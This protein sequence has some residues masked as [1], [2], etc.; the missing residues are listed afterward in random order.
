MSLQ[1]KNFIR[2]LPEISNRIKMHGF[3][4][5]LIILSPPPDNLLKTF[6]I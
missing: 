4:N 2:N 3:E 5:D 6:I 1:P